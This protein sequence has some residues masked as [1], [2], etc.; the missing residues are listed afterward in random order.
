V[1]IRASSS[2]QIDTLVANLGAESAV[3]RESAVA[4]LTLFGARAVEKLIAL[5][6]SDAPSAARAGAFRALD[7]IAD[8]RALD[9][10]LR[11]ASSHDAAVAAAAIGVARVFIRGPRSAAVVDAMTTAAL[12]PARADAIRVAALRALADLDARTIAPLLKTLAAD[13]SGAVR[14]EVALHTGTRA[15][16]KR[17][18]PAEA[19]SKAA[20][21]LGDDPRALH[22]AIVAAGE[23]ADLPLLLSIVERVRERETKEPPARRMQWTTTRAAAH[24]VLAKRG[25]RIALYDLRESLDAAKGPLP[26]E[27]L[28]ALSAVGDASCLEPIAGAYARSAEHDRDDWWCSHLADAFRTIVAREKLTRRHA[29]MKKLEKRSPAV[30]RALMK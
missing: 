3:T 23:I 21:D 5:A 16:Q 25:S 30:A 12:D 8:P 14:S 1:A 17:V 28:S 6:K 7:G 22:T 9:A 26:V 10:A 11:A 24:A 18:D 2:R 4:R 19:L 15:R 13:A 20:Q 27:F 29:V